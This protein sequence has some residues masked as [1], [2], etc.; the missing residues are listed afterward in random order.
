VTDRIDLRRSVRAFCR[1][2]ARASPDLQDGNWRTSAR[3]HYSIRQGDW[4]GITERRNQLTNKSIRISRTV[5]RNPIPGEIGARKSQ[6]FPK[7]ARVQARAQCRA[8]FARRASVFPGLGDCSLRGGRKR[9]FR[10]ARK[11]SARIIRA[12]TRGDN[13]IV[14]ER[15][16]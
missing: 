11:K 3:F 9:T 2:L 1:C 7:R 6:T 16:A 5:Q 14:S 10:R 13:Q 8:R 12:F 15:S 4:R